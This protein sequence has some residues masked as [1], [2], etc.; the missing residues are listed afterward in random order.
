MTWIGRGSRRRMWRETRRRVDGRVGLEDVS[1]GGEGFR[2]WWV[3]KWGRVQ[4]GEE[5]R[6][7]LTELVDGGA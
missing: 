7:G 4:V 2:E 5:V 3:Q 1:K 6:M